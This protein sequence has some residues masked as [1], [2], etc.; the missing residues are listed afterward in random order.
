MM[1]E[2]LVVSLI[3]ARF[4]CSPAAGHRSV[5]RQRKRPVADIFRHGAPRKLAP[6]S[7]FRRWS[8]MGSIA[9][10]AKNDEHALAVD[11]LVRQRARNL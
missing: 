4:H 9:L 6:A 10:G 3:E 8:P 7:A 5:D 2:I 1:M 11:R